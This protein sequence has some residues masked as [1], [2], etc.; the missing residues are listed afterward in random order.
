[1]VARI[2]HST[3]KADNLG[4]GV[5]Q[6]SSTFVVIAAAARWFLNVIRRVRV[7][8]R[9]KRRVRGSVGVQRI[10]VIRRK[11]VAVR[12]RMARNILASR[13]GRS[14]ASGE[15]ANR[16]ADGIDVVAWWW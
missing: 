11:E 12:G 15:S 10:K 5:W 16:M 3:I 14:T 6:G 1:M 8:S 9:G 13:R 7:R 2:N 4:V